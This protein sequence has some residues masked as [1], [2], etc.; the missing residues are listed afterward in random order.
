MSANELAI[1]RMQVMEMAAARQITVEE[2]PGFSGL[3]HVEGR[4]IVTPPLTGHTAYLAALHELGHLIAPEGAAAD[5]LLAEVAAWEWALDA[6]VVDPTA[7]AAA[8]ALR[9]IGTYV[10]ATLVVTEELLARLRDVLTRMHALRMS[11]L[12]D[13]RRYDPGALD[14]D[15][16]LNGRV[17]RGQVVSDARW[18]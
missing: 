13:G 7:D 11:A 15:G 14:V 18:Y 8:A 9:A 17:R 4:R 12:L 2:R 16:R 10:E 1:A 6:L 3:A 5:R